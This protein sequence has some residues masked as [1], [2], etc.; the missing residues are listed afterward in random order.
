MVGAASPKS[1]FMVWCILMM[2]L[3]SCTFRYWYVFMSYFI[4]FIEIRIF[5]LSVGRKQWRCPMG[6]AV[7]QSPPCSRCL[8]LNRNAAVAVCNFKAVGGSGKSHVHHMTTSNSH[9]ETFISW[10]LLSCDV[11]MCSPYRSCSSFT[12]LRQGND[13]S[14]KQEVGERHSVVFHATTHNIV[15]V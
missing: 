4:H 7:G 2:K 14:L 1:N 15:W 9:S 8:Q 6:L 3:R 10:W 5:R 12:K 11:S 13:Y